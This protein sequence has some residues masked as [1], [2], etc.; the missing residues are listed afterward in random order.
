MSHTQVIQIAGL[1]GMAALL[2]AGTATADVIAYEATPP[3]GNAPAVATF[4]TYAG[5]ITLTLVNND[6]NPGSVGENVSAVLFSIST[7]NGGAGSSLSSSSGLERTVNGDGSYSDGS[8]VPTGWSF[9]T[10]GSNAISLDVLSGNGHAGPAHTLIGTPD[11]NNLYSDADGSIAGNPAHNPFLTNA[12]TFAISDSAATN[13][14]TIS[15]VSLQ[16]GTS[17]GKFQVTAV[18]PPAIPEPGSLV[19]A[20]TVLTG[21]IVYRAFDRRRRKRLETAG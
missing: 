11:I 7:G 17:D 19:M 15:N 13:L 16:F 2:S 10:S 9:S 20:G 1:L 4:T 8:S 12:I 3:G 6:V 21:V 14:S 18:D 5:G